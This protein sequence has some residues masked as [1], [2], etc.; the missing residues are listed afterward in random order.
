MDKS[1]VKYFDLNLQQV[2]L[3]KLRTFLIGARTSR[4]WDTKEEEGTERGLEGAEGRQPEDG[5]HSLPI[6]N[7]QRISIT[8]V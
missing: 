4:H 3:Y 1:F 6:T 5:P 2:I 7:P 8:E